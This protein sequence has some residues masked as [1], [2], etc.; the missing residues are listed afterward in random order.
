MSLPTS[1]TGS[2]PEI[3]DGSIG[4]EGANSHDDIGNF[5]VRIISGKNIAWQRK[6]VD[7]KIHFNNRLDPKEVETLARA[8]YDRGEAY[9][10]VNNGKGGPKDDRVLVYNRP[11]NYYFI[12][13]RKL[14]Y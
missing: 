10:Q 7:A 9:F 2:T 14:K 5:E 6:D 1:P 12:E 13:K 11:K 8:A 3:N 4:N